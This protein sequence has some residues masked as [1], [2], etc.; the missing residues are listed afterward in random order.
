ME[1]MEDSDEADEEL[2]DDVPRSAA[3]WK[4]QKL[5]MVEAPKEPKKQM[6]Q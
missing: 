5:G 2:M 4:L 1:D 6:D 3:F